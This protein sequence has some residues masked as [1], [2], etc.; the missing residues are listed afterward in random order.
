MAKAFVAGAHKVL[1]RAEHLSLQQLTHPFQVP[2]QSKEVQHKCRPYTQVHVNYKVQAQVNIL[3]NIKVKPLFP[4]HRQVSS[5]AT[6]GLLLAATPPLLG[7][8][9]RKVG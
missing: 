8:C 1:F 6:A 7:G 9:K 5:A 4:A 3:I 2:A